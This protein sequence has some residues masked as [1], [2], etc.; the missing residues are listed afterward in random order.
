ML[1]FSGCKKIKI[2]GTRDRHSCG[3]PSL[4]S[5]QSE[6]SSDAECDERSRSSAGAES[7]NNRVKMLGRKA[8]VAE[9]VKQTKKG[10][11]LSDTIKTECQQ[12]K[13]DL[14]QETESMEHVLET[15]KKELQFEKHLNDKLKLQLQKTEDSNSE[16]VLAL[17]DLNK[18]M[19]QKCTEISELSSKIRALRSEK[20]EPDEEKLLKR[21]I[22]N[23]YSEV[24]AHKKEKEDILMKV[25]QLTIDGE[26]LDNVSRHI[27]ST[28][29][30][31]EKEKVE[32]EQNYSE[33]LATMKQLELRVETLEEENKRQQ[34]QYSE[35]LK[36]IEKLEIQVEDLQKE[37]EN[38]AQLYEE[39][40]NT[41]T[42]EKIEKEQQAMRA[43]EVFRK[44]R[45][46]NAYRVEQLQEEIKKLSDEM[47]SKIEENEKLAQK[48]I[49]EAT[50]LQSRNE[51]LESILQKSEE[52]RRMTITQYERIVH[53][54]KEQN[55]RIY[56]KEHEDLE[57]QLASV[58]EEVDKLKHENISMKSQIDQK[59]SKEVNLNLEVKKLRLKNSEMKNHLSQVELEKE[60]LKNK[61]KN[62]NASRA[63]P[64]V[65]DG[66]SKQTEL[67]TAQ[68]KSLWDEVGS[69]KERNRIT[70]ESLKEMHERY[71]ELSLRFAEVEGERQHLVLTLR[72]LRSGKKN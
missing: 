31:T 62:T 23:L 29:Q 21:T 39:E 46:N 69:L 13:S 38:Q 15:V 36:I 51:V 17:R 32:M 67:D 30:Q 20:I 7:V 16:L 66:L 61:V 56:I 42:K 25:K 52:E 1:Q 28:L 54:V 10:H 27:Y 34:L 9:N 33:S 5:T 35:S 68:I 58:R 40:L 44:A 41:V 19:D 11:R 48:S 49:A 12:L 60:D 71:S 65:V 45:R 37:L 63:K 55:E 26:K 43:E 18:K 70:E 59:N 4:I 64:R 72:N 3:N 14:R 6:A 24:E 22:E 57:R 50:D 47:S 8:E 53:E 2:Q